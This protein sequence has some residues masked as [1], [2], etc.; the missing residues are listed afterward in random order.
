MKILIE[1]PTWLGDSIMATP[2]IENLTNYFYDSKITLIGSYIS[3][4]VLKN[5]PNVVETHVINKKYSSYYKSL[6]SIG[7]F[8][9]FFSFRGSLRSKLMKFFI[10]SNT[11]YQYDKN[12]YIGNHQVEKYNSFVNESLGIENNA[13]QLTLHFEKNN[14][15][16]KNKLLGINPG[17]TYGNSKRWYPEEFAR[18]IEKL[19]SKYDTII[20]GGAD[21][22]DIAAAIEE[23]LIEKG[24]SNYDNLAGKTSFAELVKQV[25]S[26]D[27][28]ITGDSGPMHLA[29][30]FQIPT[31]SIFGSSNDIETSQWMNLKSLIVKKNLDCQPCLKRICPLKH[32]NCMKLVKSGDILKAV[33][34][35]DQL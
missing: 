10:S 18:V 25:S 14:R 4:Q 5:H 23:Y 29:A 21:E 19:S 34:N 32:H 24:I 35:L 2:A 3:I 26:L 28:F 31:V 17:A 22:K 16:A 7:A 6:K 15:K 8:D 20:F 9:I 12:K 13:G 30:S 27:L 11:K 33:K 1:L